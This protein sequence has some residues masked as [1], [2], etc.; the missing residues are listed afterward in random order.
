M[1]HTNGKAFALVVC[2]LVLVLGGALTALPAPGDVSTPG[3]STHDSKTQTLQSRNLGTGEKLLAVVVNVTGKTIRVKGYCVYVKDGR[4]V[5]KELEKDNA[6][7]WS[8]RG[9]YVK[10]MEMRKVSGDASFKVFVMEGNDTVFESPSVSSFEPVR[11]SRK[12]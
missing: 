5:R 6:W 8:F 7:G 10:E 2:S 12:K 9:E 3:R 1:K 4:E 11:Y